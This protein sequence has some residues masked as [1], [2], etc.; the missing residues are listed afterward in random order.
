MATPLVLPSSTLYVK[1]CN[2]KLKY[3]ELQRNL[4]HLFSQYGRIA[5]VVA[6]RKDGMRGQAFIVFLDVTA[7]TAAL[8]ALQ[9]F[10]FFG[11]AIKI[12]YAKT[13]S[14]AIIVREGRV[15]PPKRAG[16]ISKGKKRPREE[17]PAA[18]EGQ[19]KKKA[20]KVQEK[21]AEAEDD[22]DDMDVQE[23]APAKPKE[24]YN[25]P[26]HILFLKDLTE[27]SKS[28]VFN[29]TLIDSVH[30]LVVASL[31][32]LFKQYKGFKEIRLV[33]G[34]KDLAFVEYETVEHASEARLR[35]SMCTFTFGYIQAT[36]KISLIA[37]DNSVHHQEMAA[38]RDVIFDIL[39]SHSLLE[40]FQA[41]PNPSESIWSVEI[42]PKDRYACLTNYFILTH[43]LQLVIAKESDV[44]RI[45]LMFHDVWEIAFDPIVEFKINDVTEVEPWLPIAIF[46]PHEGQKD[47]TTKEEVEGVLSFAREWAVTLRDRGYSDTRQALARKIGGA[48]SAEARG[49]Y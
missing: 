1:Q 35:Q 10:P 41:L 42:C 46:R 15:I 29:V 39:S 3:P 27:E 30:F 2:E 48:S 28:G 13:T 7:A 45:G 36:S 23:A 33:P 40:E 44:V 21:E 43:C 6:T 11:R 16:N 49:L 47:V 31:D 25:P 22:G 24:D 32:P 4:Y 20:A 12:E 14:N 9:G 37:T 17:D 26:H 19:E 34:K 18:V 8:R 38:L 5:D